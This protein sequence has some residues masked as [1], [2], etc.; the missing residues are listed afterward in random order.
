MKFRPNTR[1]KMTHFMLYGSNNLITDTSSCDLTICM[2]ITSLTLVITHVTTD[3]FQYILQNCMAY[4]H[5]HYVV[6]LVTLDSNSSHVDK[7]KS[8][9][10][11]ILESQLISILEE[12]RRSGTIIS[13]V[14]NITLS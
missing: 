12:M 9:S 10:I 8:S 11:N 7:S 13:W 14:I 4:S 6:Q 3:T 2:I 1:K 5:I